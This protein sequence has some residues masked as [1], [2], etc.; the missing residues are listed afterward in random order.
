MDVLILITLLC[1]LNFWECWIKILTVIN[2]SWFNR[3]VSVSSCR[4]S[5]SFSC[6]IDPL[7]NQVVWFIS[8]MDGYFGHVQTVQ[9]IGSSTLLFYGFTNGYELIT[10]SVASLV[11][12]GTFP[13]AAPINWILSEFLWDFHLLAVCRYVLRQNVI[14]PSLQTFSNSAHLCYE[15][16]LSCPVVVSLFINSFMST[17]SMHLGPL[18]LQGS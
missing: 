17:F 2:R 7:K 11:I 9:T 5:L 15:L 16:S 12:F 14:V 6:G 4:T 1:L 13:L 8:S 18:D 3:E 10:A